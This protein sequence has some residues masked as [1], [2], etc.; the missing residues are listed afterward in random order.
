MTG[1]IFRPEHGYTMNQ[2]FNGHT[3]AY[4]KR[5]AKNIKKLKGIPYLQALDQASIN[6]GF[7]S[8]RDFIDRTKAQGI[9]YKRKNNSVNQHPIV[10]VHLPDEILNINPYRKLLVAG[11]NELLKRNSISLEVVEYNEGIDNQGHIFTDLFGHP[12][13]VTWRDIGYQELQISVWWKY[14]H[15]L[16]PQANLTGNSKENFRHSSPLAKRQHYKKFVGVTASGWLER[17]EGKY[18]QG[19]DLR[20]I[21]DT[22]TRRGELMELQQI[23][24]PTPIGYLSEGKFHF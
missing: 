5:A 16:H 8:W 4:I 17:K 19:K 7:I 3:A 9:L 1:D 15:S 12:S 23:S 21:V 18:L 24:T 20:A 22:Y 11:T 6:A 14:N 10:E 13:V 2:K